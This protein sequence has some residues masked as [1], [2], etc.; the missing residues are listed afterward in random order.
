VET[1]RK[2]TV[3]GRS[4]CKH[5]KRSWNKNGMTEGLG[6]LSLYTDGFQNTCTYL[7]KD[8]INKQTNTMEEAIDEV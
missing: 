5:D 1:A 6:G 2:T 8:K 3:W 7:E 4:V